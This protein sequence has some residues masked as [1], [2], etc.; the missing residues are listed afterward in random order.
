MKNEK[1]DNKEHKRLPGVDRIIRINN[2]GIS[3]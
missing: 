1:D 2:L 3:S